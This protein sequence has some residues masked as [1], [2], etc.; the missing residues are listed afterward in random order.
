[1]PTDDSHATAAP[2]APHRRPL[3]KVR[4]IRRKVGQGAD[5]R[6]LVNELKNRSV[7]SDA[8][9]A[10][11]YAV[12]QIEGELLAHRNGDRSV[13]KPSVLGGQRQVIETALSHLERIDHEELE[14]RLRAVPP[15]RSAPNHLSAMVMQHLGGVSFQKDL[16]RLLQEDGLATDAIH[17]PNDAGFAWA[18]GAGLIPAPDAAVEEMLGRG[19]EEFV[20][21][22][23]KDAADPGFLPD[24]PLIAERRLGLDGAAK[25]QARLRNGKAEE[26]ISRIPRERRTREHFHSLQQAYQRAGML[27]L[28]QKQSKATL[29]ASRLAALKLRRSTQFMRLRADYLQRAAELAAQRDPALWQAVLGTVITHQR[30]CPEVSKAF[31]CAECAPELA[32][33]IKNARKPASAPV[34]QQT[35]PAPESTPAVAHAEGHRA[36]NPEPAAEGPSAAETRPRDDALLVAVSASANDRSSTVGLAWVAED[37]Q[38]GAATDHAGNLQEARLLALSRAVADQDD[39]D[40]PLD[41]IVTDD[42]TRQVA[43]QLL[44]QR[45]GQ[46]PVVETEF[47]SVRDLLRYLVG[48]SGRVRVLSGQVAEHHAELVREA[49]Q[50]AKFAL[51]S[52]RGG[53]TQRDLHREM[54]AIAERLGATEAVHFVSP[55]ER[56]FDPV[57]RRQGQDQRW[58]QVLHADHLAKAIFPVPDRIQDDLRKLHPGVGLRL[59]L[60]HRSPT[61]PGEK[62]LLQLRATAGDGALRLDSADWPEDFFPGIQ[63]EC[64]WQPGRRSF[65]AKT[66]RLGNPRRVGDR[67]VGYDYDPMAYTRGTAPG[68]FDARPRQELSVEDWVLRTMQILG[69]LDADGRA[70]LAEEALDRNLVELGFPADQLHLVTTAV[71][72]LLQQ[73]RIERVQGSL[74]PDGRPIYPPIRRLPSVDLLSFQPKVVE[75]PR[76]KSRRRPNPFVERRAH[77]VSGFVRR[78]P[79]GARASDEA[80]EA[81]A[82]AQRRA[83][84]ANDGPLKPGYTFVRKHRRRS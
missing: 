25:Q 6:A 49:T 52:V 84:I 5:A 13:P 2:S 77:Y 47:P 30:H 75:L 14:N 72:R 33:A 27:A 23:L 35:P 53:R 15:L 9:A 57:V 81:H 74:R 31:P 40:L 66:F 60:I 39:T 79:R 83:Q 12:W 36:S 3:N 62:K 68:G 59:T 20:A 73:G 56:A 44:R 82:E 51:D 70:V 48:Q 38:S 43:M 50:L 76:T 78:L 32:T 1:M 34:P 29:A 45:R 7:R 24:H 65:I 61:C 21:A 16:R 17:P 19:D 69:Y 42:H 28:R 80:R 64:T 41:L 10:L 63:I 37:G 4:E 11:A 22:M 55:H 58:K 54:E 46:A 18:R 8:I 67:E 26:R 71:K